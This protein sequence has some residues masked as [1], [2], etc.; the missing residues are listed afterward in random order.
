[1]AR[2][3]RW[4]DA[5]ALLV[6]ATFVISEGPRGVRSELVGL[7][8]GLDR[9]PNAVADA[10]KAVA[11]AAGV[12]GVDRTGRHLGFDTYQYPGDHV[13]RAWHASGSPYEW[14]GY[15]LPETPCHKGKTWSG[16]R[17]RLIEMG[18]GLAVIY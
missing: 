16:K 17:E 14:V 15:Y 4:I 6:A 13:M 5:A 8:G 2:R 1:M 18:W 9:A 7:T 12:T 3:T 10:G 11:A